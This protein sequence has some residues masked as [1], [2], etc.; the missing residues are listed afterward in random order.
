MRIVTKDEILSKF[1][2]QAVLGA[3]EAAFISFAKGDAQ[4]AP[5]VHLS[6]PEAA[7][8]CHIKSAHLAGDDV[9]AVK[10]AT[11]FYKNPEQGLSSSN[12]FMA[13]ISA[14]TGIPLAILQDEGVLTD[15]RTALAGVLANRV[16]RR[17]DAQVLGIVGS[18]IQAGLQAEL[19]CELLGFQRLVLWARSE[20]KL[21][22]LAD[23]L[24]EKLPE[25]DVTI[26]ASAQDLCAQAEVIVT[27]TAATQPLIQSDW[28]RPGTHITA[29]GADSP[30]KQELD[31][32]LFARA[33]RVI[34][35]SPSQ[36]VEHGETANAIRAGTVSEAELIPLGRALAEAP[37]ARAPE[38]ITLA[39]LTGVAVQD[40][41][42]SNS[43][44][45]KLA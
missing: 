3:I 29:V 4:V 12:G 7:G 5:V 9:F 44:W 43:V 10:L 17:A 19:A 13:L 45:R 8:E 30:G 15:L 16:G 42:I 25:V 37:L 26:A 27:T 41:A 31:A 6:F 20:G 14:R 18:G 28:V 21:A 2:K 22:A 36:C 34:V 32:A 33:A 11:G 23:Q 40:V 39:D 35:D 24:R 38:D 1:D